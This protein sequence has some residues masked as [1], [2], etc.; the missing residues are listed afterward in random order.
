MRKESPHRRKRSRAARQSSAA[1]TL[2]RL[3]QSPQTS[4]TSRASQVGT[5]IGGLRGQLVL[6]THSL[7]S[8]QA[9]RQRTAQPTNAL[10]AQRTGVIGAA[11]ATTGAHTT[12]P[13]SRASQVTSAARRLWARYD[14][15]WLLLAL[16]VI[17]AFALRIYGINWDA[18]NHLHPDE[19]E[20]VFR[21]MCLS[22]PGGPRVGSCDPAYTGPGWFFNIAS[23][24]NPHFFA[25]GSFPLYLLAAVAR[26]LAW[27]T[28]ITHGAFHPSDG[29]SWDDF[30]HFT[31]IG[32][33]LSALFDTGSVL[34][35]GLIARRLAGRWAG[36]LAAAFVAVIPFE[37]QVAHFY[38]VDTVLLFFVLLTLLACVILVQSRRPAP[39]TADAD[40]DG[41]SQALDEADEEDEDYYDT[42]ALQ[43]LPTTVGRDSRSPQG[44]AGLGETLG[45]VWR[46]WGL[47]VF[48]G[49][50]F[51][52]AMASKIS[53]LPLLAPIVIALFLLWR[54]RGFEVT[55]LA[56]AGAV[57]AAL[58]TFIVTSPYA[59]I[60]WKDFQAQTQE[61]TQLSQGLLDYPYVRQFANTTPY[62][63]QIH[64]MLLYDMG[65]AL[66][67]L[68]IIG[69]LWAMWR[70]WRSI[71]SDWS[72]IVV[73]VLGYFAVIGDAYTKFTRYMLPVFAPLAICGACAIVA[74]AVA[75]PNPIALWR[76]LSQWVGSQRLFGGGHAG[77]AA[78]AIQAMQATQAT[79][80]GPIKRRYA[81]I[82]VALALVVL[83]CTA[84]EALALDNIYS[85]PNSR[86]QASEWLYDHLPAG[87]TVTY[88]VWDDPLPIQVPAAYTRDGVPYT[89]AGYPINPSEYGQIGLNLY[90]QDTTA[91]AQ[92]LAQS[93]ATANAVVI[94][95]QRLLKSIPKLPD[96]YPMTIRYY[97][98]L[99]AGKLGFHLAYHI[100][101][102]PNL[103]GIT[104]N[105]T[106]A[107]ESFSVY[108]HPPVWIFFRTGRGLTA[109]QIDTLLTQG[110]SLPPVSNRA[111]SQ[112]PL[113]LSPQDA[114]ADA[115]SA[116]LGVQFPATSL[117]NQ[118]PLLW[119]LI[120]VELLGVV[121]FPL[122]F[123]VFPGLY[124]K[125]WGLSKTLGLLVLAYLVWLPASLRILPFAG[126]SVALM[127]AVLAAAGAG[128][129]WLRREALWAFVRAKWRPL[130]LCEILFLVTFLAFTYVRALD[131]DLWHI[132]RGG[133]KP[134]E[135]AFLDAILRSR[136]LPP[137]DPW[138]SGGYINYYYYGQYLIA[139]LIKLT[140]IVPTVAFNLALPLLFGMT[141]TGAFSVVSGLTRRW[142]AGVAGGVALVV[143]G[144]LD[145]FEQ[146]IA[147]WQDA[148]KGMVPPAFDYWRSSRVIPYTINEFP[149]WS[150]LYGDLHAHLI[151]LPIVVL[152]IGC[153][154]SLLGA[155]LSD[156]P[157]A[158][159]RKGWALRAAPTLAAIA[160]A[161]GAAWC[162]NTW[163]VPT[164][165]LLAAAALALALLP[166]GTLA[167][168]WRAVWARVNW[169]TVRGYLVALALTFGAT[170]ALYL[171][172]HS[173]FQNFTSGTGTVTT[174]TDPGQFFTLFGLW[175]FLTASFLTLEL[176]DR[177]EARRLAWGVALRRFFAPTDGDDDGLAYAGVPSG[178][179]SATNDDL[180]DGDYG[181]Y[182]SSAPTGGAY[183]LSGGA[184]ALTRTATPA[185]APTARLL[186]VGV[187]SALALD[188]AYHTSLKALLV[189]MIV[190]GLF[191]GLNPRHSKAKLFT[192]ALLLLGLGVALGVELIYVRDFL[193]N[194]V[195]ERMNTVFKFYYQ[196]W[197][198][199]ALGSA[200]AFTQLVTRL[201]GDPVT[202]TA[203]DNKDTSSHS[204]SHR[205]GK[206]SGVRS[207]E[208]QPAFPTSDL[209]DATE[210]DATEDNTPANTLRSPKDIMGALVMAARPLVKAAWLLTL[211]GL[212]AGSL[213]FLFAGTAVRVQDPSIW[214][215]V[216]P[217]PGG[218]QPQGLSLD[219]MAYMRGW[220]P[221]DYAA[222]NWMNEH[223]GGDPTIVE[224]SNGPYAWY[225][226]VSIY[227][228]LPSVLGWSSHESQQRYPDAVYARQ[229]DVQNFY[230]ESDPAA[231]AAFL[232]QYG[233]RY[234]YVGVLERTCYMTDSSNN[235]VGMS[236]PALAKYDTL[237]HEGILRVV[238]QQQQTT[239]YEVVG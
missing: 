140:G 233:V 174:P 107:D 237:V 200:L 13:T 162:T 144:N 195:W 119:W 25:Y 153:C 238:Y 152:I 31:L 9:T 58:V 172:F 3:A 165:A 186:L 193:D 168:G 141:F 36:A 49:V 202:Q 185:W 203:E 125:G 207:V 178:A 213:V 20:I 201:I 86:V 77:S 57:A 93:L 38:A 143:M 4:Q 28:H 2:Q 199:L 64:Q 158:F 65:L 61:Q 37:V 228:G 50:A 231:A 75:R 224:A 164:Y 73:F 27:L 45:S 223:I 184:L 181:D 127:F 220:Y 188:I 177:I 166:T 180:D 173:G 156:S 155:K 103:F 142:W 157:T 161:L 217:P 109:S 147:R 15:T 206:G 169:P 81:I 74:F 29:G 204:P 146:E 33:A 159:G 191:L 151:D 216:A 131:P 136:Y 205:Y 221:Q 30:N 121:T 12:A 59:L 133:E 190:V 227:T 95:S 85:A 183:T 19:R 120:I 90:D 63:Y 14:W 118:I 68:G 21:A 123:H 17:A 208:P 129:A 5:P 116:P 194:S 196:V 113:L 154:A 163:D 48:V 187:L 41:D 43:S 108:D 226:R 79:P 225:G 239:I 130:L 117:P 91:K 149:Y 97:Q 87:S 40:D 6:N 210:D 148:L 132:Y 218:V 212:I 167:G 42:T 46:A 105:D 111:G 198:L 230:G 69:L 100:E 26:G 39:Q 235:C 232:R 134:M 96:R 55:M 135:I 128:V 138:F 1:P 10:A 106:G 214:A 99:F 101:T 24:L 62:V 98:L 175:L 179:A 236:A 209:Y 66:G 189:L 72:I 89:A 11:P 51:G 34:V 52:L 78:P 160:L 229:A 222:I 92:Q 137:Y 44:E 122:A 192:Y 80:V 170:Y 83:A 110:L 7:L 60:D 35:S 47:G 18:N 53:A 71:D 176:Y 16:V 215:A 211:T 115:Q 114:K 32:R 8:T 104:I 112:K 219:G 197:T 124:D 88:E 102:H 126:W 182:A 76:R 67:L 94:N 84:F 23:P 150:F 139:V 234:V 54:R 82:G 70:V 22:F 145:G 171:P 56:A